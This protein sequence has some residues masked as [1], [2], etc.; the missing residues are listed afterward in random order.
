MRTSTH[1]AKFCAYVGIMALFMLQVEAL[2]HLHVDDDPDD[3]CHVCVL[4]DH[5]DVSAPVP[6]TAVPA[7]GSATH[8]LAFVRRIDAAPRYRRN[9]RAPPASRA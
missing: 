5:N 4:L 9:P 6:A 7:Y 3:Q 8:A 2:E 1:I